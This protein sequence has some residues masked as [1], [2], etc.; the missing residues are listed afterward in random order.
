[1]ARKPSDLEANLYDALHKLFSKEEIASLSWELNIDGEDLDGSS[2]QA[3]ARDLVEHA[4][5]G[6]KTNHLARLVTRERP[7]AQLFKPRFRLFGRRDA[8][9]PYRVEDWDE[10]TVG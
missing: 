8:P 3:M 1:M 9:K 10:P 4:A 6:G 7:N 5:A 2:K